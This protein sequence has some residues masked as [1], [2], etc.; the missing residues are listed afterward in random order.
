VQQRDDADAI[1]TG[2]VGKSLIV[3]VVVEQIVLPYDGWLQTEVSS[4][5]ILCFSEGID[6]LNVESRA[7]LIWGKVA[8]RITILAIN[9]LY[10]HDVK[11]SFFLDIFDFVGNNLILV[12]NINL[13]FYDVIIIEKKEMFIVFRPDCCVKFLCS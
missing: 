13:A 2:N 5:F 11:V 6:A 9:Y 3:L 8:Q 7:S 10:V 1:I 12:F 4:L